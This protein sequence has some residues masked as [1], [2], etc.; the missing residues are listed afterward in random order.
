MHYRRFPL[1]ALWTNGYLFWDDGGE[2]FFIDPGG[3]AHE[4]LDFLQQHDLKLKMVL[5]THGHLDHIAGLRDLAPLVNGQIYVGGGDAHLLRQ[6][7]RNLQ[8][9]LR[10][11]CDPV[12]DF[13]EVSEGAV[14]KAGNIEIQVMETPGHTRGGVCYLIK[15]GAESILASGDTLF[16][17]SVGRTDLEGGDQGVLEDSL[18]RLA[19]LPDGLQV[20]PGHGPETSIG[21]ERRRNPFWPA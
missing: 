16:A 11:Q 4:V 8:A 21:E 10:I 3:D 19:G 17:Q 1:G 5:L 14:L 20:L 12:Q 9:A 6:P 18:R 7:P 2:A 13:H 15:D